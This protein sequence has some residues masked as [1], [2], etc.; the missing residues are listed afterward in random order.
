MGLQ[1]TSQ[2]ESLD[3]T[4]TGDDY[5]L[6]GSLNHTSGIIKRLDVAIF[7]THED[8]VHLGNISLSETGNCS[9]NIL[10]NALIVPIAQVYDTLK[11]ELQ[12]S[13]SQK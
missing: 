10:N 13:I 2:T 3:F 1:I 8:G 12:A 5:K 11:T 7:S 6:Q 4:Y 9:M